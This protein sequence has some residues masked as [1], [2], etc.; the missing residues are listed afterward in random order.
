MKNFFL[1]IISF[2]FL[3]GCSNDSEEKSNTS[4]Y[5]GK[6]TL[7]KMTG[8]MQNH[9]TVGGA[10][11]WQETY[12]FYDNW[13]FIKIRNQNNVITTATGTYA[14]KNNSDTLYLELTYT[15]ESPIIGSCYGNLKEELFFSDK[16]TL[17]STWRNCDGP[18]L[19]YQKLQYYY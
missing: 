16:N 4:D 9:E 19:D 2:L 15:S 13:T 10:M 7:V 1:L 3:A 12:E 6:W 11:S 8:S 18:G 17:S 14:T 5:H